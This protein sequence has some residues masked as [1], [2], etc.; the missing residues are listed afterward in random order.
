[1]TTGAAG[2]PAGHHVITAVHGGR[3]SAGGVLHSGLWLQVLTSGGVW[4]RVRMAEMREM[5]REIGASCTDQGGTAW[6]GHRAAFEIK[7][8]VFGSQK[9]HW[10]CGK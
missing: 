9:R 1:V 3:V 2:R 6:A 7:F 10:C 5:G 8:R 4:L